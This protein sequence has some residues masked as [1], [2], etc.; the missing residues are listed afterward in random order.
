MQIAASNLEILHMLTGLVALAICLLGIYRHKSPVRMVYM[1]PNDSWLKWLKRRPTADFIDEIIDIVYKYSDDSFLKIAN[2]LGLDNTL[3]IYCHIR[4]IGYMFRIKLGSTLTIIEQFR[5]CADSDPYYLHV[6]D[7]SFHLHFKTI[8]ESKMDTVK[9]LAR[10]R[11][12]QELV[13]TLF[14]V[15]VTKLCF[16]LFLVS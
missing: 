1:P 2:Q 11:N 14:A 8:L 12:L 9:R 13:I 7:P 3:L 16:W 5:Y 10:K 6:A 15:V 4:R